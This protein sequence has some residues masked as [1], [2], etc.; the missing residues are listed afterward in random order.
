MANTVRGALIGIVET[1]PGVSGGTV[2]LVVGIYDDLIASAHHATTAARRLI[3]GPH[4]R[5]GFAEEIRHVQW[6]LVIPVLVGMAIAVFTVAGPMKMLV[7]Q[8]PQHVRA[9]FFGMVLASVLVPLKLAGR[10]LKP[11]DGVIFAIA[12]IATF[13]LLSLPSMRLQPNPVTI[14][15][16][17]A[18]AVSALVLPGVSGSFLLLTFGLYE[19]TLNAVHERDFGY[20]G[21]FLLGAL[22]GLVFIVK[23]LRWLLT[24]HHRSTMVALT[25][26]MVG[27]LRSLWPWQ[28]E[29]SRLQGIGENWGSLLGIMLL[30]AAAVLGLLLVE[31]RTR[32]RSVEQIPD[33]RVGQQAPRRAQ[34]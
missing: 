27:A 4:R 28:S 2:A 17:A 29:D 30:G 33:D 15:A 11:R 22:L 24:H 14:V 23:A 34:P 1:I 9:A 12:L 7:E 25:G 21:L 6:A 5:E 8:H 31:S 26:L 18:L 20:L 10:P 13:V 32:G 19:S 3:A 16:T